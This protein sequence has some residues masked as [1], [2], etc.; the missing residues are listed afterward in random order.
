MIINQI[1][2]GAGN[3]GTVVDS[4]DI[5][6][7][8]ANKN[9][10]N[11]V[12]T[13]PSSAWAL[14][15]ITTPAGNRNATAGYWN[16]RLYV[17]WPMN[18][19]TGINAV[20][21]YDF[22]TQT[23][24]TLTGMAF[25]SKRGQSYQVGSKVYMH[26]GL[27]SGAMNTL[28]YYDCATETFTT[29]L[30]ESL[31]GSVYTQAGGD[32]DTIYLGLGNYLYKYV[33]STATYSQVSGTALGG[34]NYSS[35]LYAAGEL[36]FRY[37]TIFKKYNISTDTWTTLC[38]ITTGTSTIYD[39]ILRGKVIYFISQLSIDTTYKYDIDT[40]SMTSWDSNNRAQAG[41]IIAKN[42]IYEVGGLSGYTV[43]NTIYTLSFGG[44]YA[45][46]SKYA[47]I[48]IAQADNLDLT[49]GEP[50]PTQLPYP[51]DTSLPFRLKL[52][53]DATVTDTIN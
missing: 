3:A 43:Y 19:S 25:W 49:V 47:G 6:V 10:G 29:I 53:M 41:Y 33:I 46:V 30:T 24:T 20:Y 36:Y 18:A 14:S 1:I 5:Y 7:A 2:K 26:I 38:N 32:N 13:T 52:Q 12:W 27:A 39:M 48:T 28:A 44:G 17:I 40:D 16:N 45:A 9:D 23:W 22:A 51:T 31:V 21:R 11:Y 15:S 37:G 42:V 34:T 4:G 8:G 35:L 50:M